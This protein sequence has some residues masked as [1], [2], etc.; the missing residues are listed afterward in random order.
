MPVEVEAKVPA[1]EEVEVRVE[2]GGSVPAAAWEDAR[3]KSSYNVFMPRPRKIRR[4]RSN[5]EVLYFKPR[6]IP[7]KN[8]EEEVLLPDEVEALRLYH[9]NELDQ[10]TSSKK[11]DISQSTFHRLLLSAEKKIS[12]AIINGK[13]IK[14]DLPKNNL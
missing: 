6:G 13:A 9:V 10:I 2:E 1:P 4:I 12:R 11:M 8:L 14:I 5:P 3:R 7:L